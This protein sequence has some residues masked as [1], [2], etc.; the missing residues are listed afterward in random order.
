MIYN[1]HLESRVYEFARNS[2][3]PMGYDIV[4]IRINSGKKYKNIQIMLERIEGQ[5][6]NIKDCETVSRHLSLLFEVE[7]IIE[8]DY[9]LEISSTGVNKPLTR[10]EDFKKAISNYVKIISKIPLNN[11][12]R[13]FGQVLKC[14]DDLIT[15]KLADSE[16]IMD[17]PFNNMTDAHIEF[18]HNKD[19]YNKIKNKKGAK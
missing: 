4:R 18:F 3:V 19:K 5:A 15:L 10:V 2:I 7:E 8:G 17:I 13:F 6:I 9:N 16:N 11:Q 1:T 12:R 14:E